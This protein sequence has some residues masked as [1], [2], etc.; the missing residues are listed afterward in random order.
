ME[1]YCMKNDSSQLVELFHASV[2]TSRH[3]L[4][5]LLIAN[6]GLIDG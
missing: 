2:G 6:Y 5:T 1:D 3:R 4:V